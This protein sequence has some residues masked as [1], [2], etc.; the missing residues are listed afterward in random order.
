MRRPAGLTRYALR[1]LLQAV[2]LL[3]AAA[4]VVFLLLHLAP[5]DPAA[6]YLHPDIPAEVARQV[7][8]DLGLGRPLHE[9]YL[10][11]L[12]A[13][14]RGDLGYSVSQGQPVARAIGGA[15]PNTLLLG[16]AALLISF[17]VGAPVGL[18]QGTR[19]GA[20]ADRALSTVTL[21]AYSVP[22]FWVALLLLLVF[23]SGPVREL[24]PL[25][26]T[27]TTAVGHDLLGLGARIADRLRHLV[28]PAAALA[29]APTAAVV[30]HARSAA[31]EARDSDHVRAARGRGLSEWAVAWRHV[32]QNALL[33]L[34][35]LLGLYVPR[36][37]GGAVVLEFIFSWSG[38]G[39]LLYR[40][41]LARDY[42]LVLAATL[43]F[44]VLVV[45]GNLLADLLYAAADP[46][47][48]YGGRRG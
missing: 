1:R 25:P 8:R 46:R 10:S 12:G 45:A 47:V 28:L 15:L 13:L 30:R 44:A 26:L 31:L 37:L 23:S 27:G 34:T 16:G 17:S 18:Y 33:P 7:R 38:M 9:Q 48:R 42:P 32:V 29:V 21:V 43:L 19:A 20:V 11:W 40:G 24:V 14:L 39:R 2:P 6:A 36:F 5:G 4:S 41:V 35:S 22:G 3:L